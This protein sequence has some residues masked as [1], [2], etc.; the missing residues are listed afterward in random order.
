MTKFFTSHLTLCS[1]CQIYGEDFVNFS[2]FSRKYELYS[3]TGPPGSDNPEVVT[4]PPSS[5]NVVHSIVKGQQNTQ[6]TT[7]HTNSRTFLFEQCRI[8]LLP[9]TKIH[10][11][12][13]TIFH[14]STDV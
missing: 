1:K 11:F 9:K 12:L 14:F 8:L 13:S 3:P 7:T 2:G 4:L 6:V 5:K 10:F